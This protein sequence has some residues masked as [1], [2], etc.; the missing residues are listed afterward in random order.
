MKSLLITL[1]TYNE[2]GNIERLIPELLAVAPNAAILVIDDNSPDGTGEVA[3]EISRQ[4]CRVTAIH[5][6]A[7]QGLGTATVLGFQYGIDHQYDLL[8]NMDA[9]FSHRPEYIPQMCRLMSNCDVAIGSRYIPGGDVIG[10]PL[11]RYVMSYLINA[12]ARFWLRLKTRDN[13]GSFRCYR[14]S[15]LSLVDWGRVLSRGF[16]IQEEI[17]YRCRRVGCRFSELPIIFEDRR[18]GTTKI[19]IKESLRAAFNIM[20]LGLQNLRGTPVHQSTR[21]VVM[22]PDRDGAGQ[23]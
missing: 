15:C 18:V 10:W 7:K 6:P 5:R 16:A 17:L 20:Q 22:I 4:D 13:S 23:G 8:I 1:C 14:V 11:R 21:T 9:D 12:W 19:S 3:D 2:R